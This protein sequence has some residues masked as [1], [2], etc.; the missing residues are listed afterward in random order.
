MQCND[1]HWLRGLNCLNCQWAQSDRPRQWEVAE[2]EMI[3]YLE[4]S[5]VGHS[6]SDGLYMWIKNIGI[7]LFLIKAISLQ[8]CSK[9]SV[10]DLLQCVTIVSTCFPNTSHMCSMRYPRSSS[11]SV[12]LPSPF[13]SAYIWVL[14]QCVII[15]LFSH[16]SRCVLW[17]ECNAM[18]LWPLRL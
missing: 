14:L 12:I 6:D 18:S 15:V 11:S 8:S 5:H 17:V 7:E 13:S 9:F 1:H 10:A 4:I 3:I 16:S 2:T